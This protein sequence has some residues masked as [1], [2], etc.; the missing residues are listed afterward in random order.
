MFYPIPSIR[1]AK[2]YVVDVL[3][4]HDKFSLEQVAIAYNG[5][6]IITPQVRALVSLLV[7]TGYAT[8][9]NGVYTRT[10]KPRN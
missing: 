10:E 6:G 1:T 2:S 8:E 4:P 3:N 5:D 7:R 9:V